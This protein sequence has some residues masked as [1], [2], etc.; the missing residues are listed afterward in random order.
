MYLSVSIAPAIC[1]HLSGSIPYLPYKI[2]T[3]LP[4]YASLYP[5][6]IQ[7]KPKYYLSIRIH[8][9]LVSVVTSLFWV[10]VWVYGIGLGQGG[11]RQKFVRHKQ[12]TKLCLCQLDS[13]KSCCELRSRPPHTLPPPFPC[14]HRRP[15]PPSP[16]DSLVFS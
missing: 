4:N 5:S 9:Y 13:P 16:C 3:Y 8:L 11:I 12:N 15:P 6:N 10:F 2:R 7:L 1:L 14:A